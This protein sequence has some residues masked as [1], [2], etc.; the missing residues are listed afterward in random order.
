LWSSDETVVL[1]Q[2]HG[3]FTHEYIPE[4]GLRWARPFVMGSASATQVA[5]GANNSFTR[6]S[7]GLGGG[8]K[9]YFTRH[10][11]LRMQGEWLGSVT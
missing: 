11:V 3:D 8:I 1:D 10:L 7:F 2:F 9:V 6:F 5:G 4:E